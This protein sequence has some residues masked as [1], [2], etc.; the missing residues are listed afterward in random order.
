MKEKGQSLI[1]VMVALGVAVIIITAIV[2][3]VVLAVVNTQIAK[4]QNLATH[5][6]RQGVEVL[7]QL[8]LS[9]WGTFSGYAGPYCLGKDVRLAP[10]TEA[11][12]EENPTNNFRREVNVVSPAQTEDRDGNECELSPAGSGVFGSYVVVTVSWTD[13]KCQ[14]QNTFCHSV[15]LD[16]CFQNLSSVPAP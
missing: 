1:E 7:R 6:A 11:F 15:R 13:N 4:T 9:D 3:A 16:S 8:S 5:Y 10:K 14:D 2:M 12:C